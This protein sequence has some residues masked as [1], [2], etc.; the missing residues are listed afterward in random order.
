MQGRAAD[1]LPACFRLL[2]AAVEAFCS[3]TDDLDNS[4][5]VQQGCAPRPPFPPSHVLRSGVGSAL[6]TPR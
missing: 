4:P 5:L 2:E 6:A 1:L 3:S